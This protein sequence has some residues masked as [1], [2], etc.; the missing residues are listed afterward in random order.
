MINLYQQAIQ[1][2][3]AETSGAQ[4]IPSILVRI[5]EKIDCE[6]MMAQ[7][8]KQNAKLKENSHLQNV[9]KR[10]NDFLERTSKFETI[11][12]RKILQNTQIT[13]E[14]ELKE[15]SFKPKTKQYR[16]PKENTPKCEIIYQGKRHKLQP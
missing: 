13:K 8:Y 6:M 3:E 14:K 9:S 2:E 11:K 10:F 15:C 5:Q 7:K 1:E 4:I 16:K 12:S